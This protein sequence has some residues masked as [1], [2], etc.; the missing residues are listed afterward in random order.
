LKLIIILILT[1]GIKEIKSLNNQQYLRL[2]LLYNHKNKMQKMQKATV[3]LALI[4]GAKAL[5]VDAESEPSISESCKVYTGRLG[6]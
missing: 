1:L 3:V 5:K 2:P 4:Y 6:T